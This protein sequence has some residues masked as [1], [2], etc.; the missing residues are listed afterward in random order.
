VNP[1]ILRTKKWIDRLRVKILKIKNNPART[2][3]RGAEKVD[4][5]TVR[6]VTGYLKAKIINTML[7]K[8]P[9]IHA[10]TGVKYFMS[11]ICELPFFL[12]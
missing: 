12:Q 1:R 3:S 5:P 4:K 10:D 2:G 8:S 9:T 6:T 7:V 11:S